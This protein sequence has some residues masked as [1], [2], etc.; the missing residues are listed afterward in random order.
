MHGRVYAQTDSSRVIGKSRAG[1]AEIG[2]SVDELYNRY[3]RTTPRWSTCTRRACSRCRGN[4]HPRE[5][6]RK[7][8]HA[9]G[10]RWSEGWT[11]SRITVSDAGFRTEKGIGP[12]STL[13]I[14]ERPMLW[15]DRFRGRRPGGGC[16]NARA[17]FHPG[18]ERGPAEM[19][20]EPE[21]GPD[22]GFGKDR[23]G[24]GV[25]TGKFWISDCGL[26]SGK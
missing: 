18:Q 17:E 21:S 26:R 9:R 10:D 24:I 15:T 12:G 25:L 7:T 14:C 6:G 22:T 16:G 1:L 11:V 19:V 13:G 4:P 20:R 5:R 23:E 8:V 2:I 3:E